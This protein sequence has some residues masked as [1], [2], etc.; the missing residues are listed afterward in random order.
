MPDDD[1]DREFDDGLVTEDTEFLE[2]ASPDLFDDPTADPWDVDEPEPEPEE[3]EDY[4][5]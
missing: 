1:Y 2:P 4:D 3:D 5:L